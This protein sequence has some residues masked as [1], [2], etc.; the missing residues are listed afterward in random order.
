MEKAI[1]KG[2]MEGDLRIVCMFAC[3]FS[4]LP[5]TWV[6]R[7]SHPFVL[8]LFW[9][10]PPL[11]H[12]DRPGLNLGAGHPTR[13]GS[14]SFSH[15]REESVTC[16]GFDEREKTRSCHIPH[17]CPLGG[18]SVRIHQIVCGHSGRHTHI[19]EQDCQRGVHGE[20]H[21]E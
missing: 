6:S 2:I 12:L 3:V 10:A 5:M 9:V 21:R 16:L 14:E 15:S 8:L 18:H 7:R 13:T 1:D 4:P 11:S 19:V 17:I 20:Q